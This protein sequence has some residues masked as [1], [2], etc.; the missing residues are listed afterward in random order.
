MSDIYIN[1]KP[2]HRVEI[3]HYM[4][5]TIAHL[6]SLVILS[7]DD[8]LAHRYQHSICVAREISE[9][10]SDAFVTG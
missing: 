2:S 3:M 5:K 8:I 6:N 4:S 1:I 7:D 10:P 9:T